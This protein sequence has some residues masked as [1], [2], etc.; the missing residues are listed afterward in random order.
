M[1][2]KCYEAHINCIHKLKKEIYKSTLEADHNGFQ[3]QLKIK[4]KNRRGEQMK[5][6]MIEN[7]NTIYIYINKPINAALRNICMI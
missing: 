2:E 6:F 5:W 7:N 4:K 1:N 3:S